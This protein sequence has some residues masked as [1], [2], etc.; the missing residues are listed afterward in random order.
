FG[1]P[2]EHLPAIRRNSAGRKLAVQA[3]P[4]DDPNQHLQGVLS[5]IDN[6]VDT[7]TGTI[8]LKATFENKNGVLWPGQFVNVALTLDQRNDAIVV[9]SEAVQAGQTGQ[10]IF[11]VKADQSVEPRVVKVGPTHG[12]K[13]IIEQGIA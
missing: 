4:Q 2:E 9:P 1:V 12:T 11:V 7:N 8:H 13:V 6:T 10:M 5:V 3:S